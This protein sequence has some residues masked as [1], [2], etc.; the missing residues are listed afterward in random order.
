M[1]ENEYI[2]GKSVTTDQINNRQYV[3]NSSSITAEETIQQHLR[4]W[5]EENS[6]GMYSLVIENMKGTDK[7]S[8]Y[9]EGSCKNYPN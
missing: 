3:S 2:V 6:Q 7:L 9:K 4:Y 5:Q 8:P 1:S